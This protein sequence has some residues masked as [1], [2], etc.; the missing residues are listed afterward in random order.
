VTDEQM[1]NLPRSA[2]HDRINDYLTARWTREEEQ[3]E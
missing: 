1:E 3:G 2:W